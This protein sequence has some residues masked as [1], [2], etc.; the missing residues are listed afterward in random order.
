MIHIGPIQK[1]QQADHARVWAPVKI[2]LDSEHELFFQVDSAYFDALTD[3]RSDGFVVS[4]LP[5]ALARGEDIHFETPM[6]QQLYFQMKHF[7][8]PTLVKKGFGKA[9]SLNGPSRSDQLNSQ[10]GAG[11]GF[12]AGVDS[13]YTFL[14]NRQH[15]EDRFRLTHLTLFN[16][17]SHGDYG[18]E[19]AYQMFK[20]R[21]QLSIKFAEEEGYP[22]ILLHSNISEILQMPFIASHTFRT[23]GAVLTLQNLF[24]VYYFSSGYPAVLDFNTGDTASFDLWSLPLLSTEST[25]VY[26]FDGYSARQDKLKQIA[27]SSI[28][29]KYLNVCQVSDV[30]CGQC[31]KCRRT[32][33]G[34]Y[35]L[36]HL[37]DYQQVFDVARFK[38]H[39]NRELGFLLFMRQQ[40]GS[41]RPYNEIYQ[42]LKDNGLP[43]PLSAYGHQLVYYF[44]HLFRNNE[45]AKS[46]YFKYLKK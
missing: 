35:A 8:I 22:L 24:S 30:N 44:K 23:I 36:K 38:K 19:E 27:D 18:G 32:Q 9:F 41:A 3:Q 5:L 40:K 13:L 2:G 46:F 21:S 10:N 25:Q 12:S 39:L 26:S 42:S 11:T 28:A 15:A 37:D 45:W 33:L 6:S 43:I 16:V 7:L 1:Q 20:D 14:A 17:G 31:E 34:L 29:Q 4:L